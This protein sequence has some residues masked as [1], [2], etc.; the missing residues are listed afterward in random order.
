MMA[1]VV[2]S[3]ETQQVKQDDGF[4]DA[5]MER[6][7]PHALVIGRDGRLEQLHGG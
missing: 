3:A 4:L 6:Q 1:S 5:G 7:G 2:K